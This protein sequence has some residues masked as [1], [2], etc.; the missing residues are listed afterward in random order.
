MDIDVLMRDC[1][2][3]EGT[4]M[5]RLTPN[6]AGPYGLVLLRA[7]ANGDPHETA[8]LPLPES[9]L[10]STRAQALKRLAGIGLITRD[11]RYGAHGGQ[12]L[13]WSQITAVG[14]A[15]L[16]EHRHATV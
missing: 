14:V 2:C 7:L 3:C 4:G 5:V 12:R 9:G 6:D 8:E 13:Y 16:Q 10:A 1:P 15:L 11:K